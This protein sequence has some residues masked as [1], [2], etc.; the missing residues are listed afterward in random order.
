MKRTF[1]SLANELEKESLK[2][3]ANIYKEEKISAIIRYSKKI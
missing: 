3:E 1:L 2:V